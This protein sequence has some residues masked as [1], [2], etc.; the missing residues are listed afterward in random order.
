VDEGAP[1][2]ASADDGMKATIAGIMA[3]RAVMSRTTQTIA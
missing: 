3:H 2:P 1:V